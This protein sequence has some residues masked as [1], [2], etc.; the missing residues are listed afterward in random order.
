MTL[1]P[2]TRRSNAGLFAGD[3]DRV[4]REALSMGM[5]TIL[6]ARRIVLLATGP[7]KAGCVRRMIEGPLTTMLPASFLQLHHD[8]EVM[9]DEAAARDLN[10]S[11]AAASGRAAGSVN[12]RAD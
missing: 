4:P 5:A 3:P 12:R 10:G 2:E 7:S 8:V 6:Q 1:R 9:V 11:D